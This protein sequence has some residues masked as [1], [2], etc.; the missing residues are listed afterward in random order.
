M[1]NRLDI[2]DMWVNRV[3]ENG[4]KYGVFADYHYYGVGDMGG[5]L[6]EKDVVNAVKSLNNPDG[7][8]K[9]I[10]AS[11]Q[12]MYND[13]TEQ[14]KAKLPRYK[15]DFLLTQHSAGFDN[16]AGIYETLEQ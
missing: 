9:V 6:R 7:K 5:R 8:I 15:G 3:E 1:N 10:L 2:D 14:Q 16:L 13:I 11:S 12:Q 4:Q